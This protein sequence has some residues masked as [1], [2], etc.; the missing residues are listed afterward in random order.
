MRTSSA[1]TGGRT[2]SGKDKERNRRARKKGGKAGSRMSKSILAVPLEAVHKLDK[3]ANAVRGMAD[4]RLSSRG[5]AEQA[6]TPGGFF[7]SAEQ[8]GESGDHGCG[9]ENARRPSA[10]VIQPDLLGRRPIDTP[11][12]MHQLP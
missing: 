1:R 10:S 3:A 6:G 12:G 11:S 4:L 5:A 8:C 9:R 7:I 2:P